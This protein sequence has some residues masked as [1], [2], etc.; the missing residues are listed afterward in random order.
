MH[1]PEISERY[2]LLLEAYLHGCGNYLQELIKQ[3]EILQGLESVA[4]HI[5]TVPSSDRREILIS[6][7]RD[8]ELP[9]KFQ[10]PLDPTWEAQS[11]VYEKCKY[12]DSKKL[13]LWLVM[14]NADPTCNKP[15]V[16]IFKSGDDLRQDMLTLQIIR[17]IDKI[18]FIP[19]T[20]FSL[21]HSHSHSHST[22]I[23]PLIHHLNID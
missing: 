10:L 16:V 20:F 11:F 2:G 22:P 18:T 14:T 5:K 21:S 1:V 9:D 17:I 4:N 3:N 7:L 8:I 23:P 6:K 12:M 15:I 19:F 13:P